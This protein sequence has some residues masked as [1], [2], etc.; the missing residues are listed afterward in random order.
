[1]V[2]LYNS[3][4]REGLKEVL[5]RTRRNLLISSPYIKVREADWVCN[6]LAK[7]SESR[8]RLQLLTDVRTE[9]VLNGSLD[10]K[11]LTLFAE[12]LQNTII[13]NLPRIHAKVYI[14]DSDFALI[15][16]ANLTPAGLDNNFEYGV[17]VDDSSVVANVRTDLEAYARLGNILS[18]TTLDDLVKTA[19][20]ISLE[21]RRLQKSAGRRLRKRFSDRLRSANYQFLQAQVGARSAHSLFSEAI[22]YSLSLGPLPTRLLHPRVQSLLPD[23]CDDSTELVINGQFFGKKWKHAVRNAQQYLKRIG[24]ISFDGKVWKLQD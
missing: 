3:P 5:S 22:I 2:R 4:V 7:T 9:N 19:D 1:M 17:G 20:D 21:Y 6:Q 8:I 13:V 24:K 10:I 14:A 18:T 15:T 11:A 23:L 12:T 16:S